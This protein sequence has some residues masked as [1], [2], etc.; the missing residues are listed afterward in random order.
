MADISPVLESGD[1]TGIA[2]SV[3]YRAYAIL[4]DRK[5]TANGGQSLDPVVYFRFPLAA[6]AA[7]ERLTAY[8]TEAAELI[9]AAVQD[10]DH[11]IIRDAIEYIRRHYR[12]KG[13]KIQDVADDVHLSPNYLSY[14]FKQIAGETVWEY[15]TRLRMEEAR[16]L[17]LHTA[18]KALRN[19]GRGRIRVARAFQP[20]F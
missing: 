6:H 20:H 2:L 13:L 18:K 5:L 12:N 14:L 19:F 8:L 11:A 3:A 4:L 1:A 15:V 7:K 10:Y 9:D 17:L 16:H